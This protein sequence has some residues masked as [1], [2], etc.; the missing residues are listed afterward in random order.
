M[1]KIIA[2]EVVN[3]KLILRKYSRLFCLF[4]L[5][6]ATLMTLLRQKEGRSGKNE[7]ATMEKDHRSDHG[8]SFD[9]HD[10]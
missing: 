9:M 1:P 4:L 8:L 2:H 3:D 5:H 6:Q 7:N 10:K